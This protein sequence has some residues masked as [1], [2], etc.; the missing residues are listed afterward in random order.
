M[1]QRLNSHAKCQIAVIGFKGRAQRVELC[2]DLPDHCRRV[3]P[4]YLSGAWLLPSG[5]RKV[6]S[7]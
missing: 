3:H 6:R 2:A 7:R 1:N 4:E 5:L